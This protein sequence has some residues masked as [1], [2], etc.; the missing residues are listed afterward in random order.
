[1]EPTGA[2]LVH[3]AAREERESMID[4]AWSIG[5]RGRR[6]DLPGLGP[7]AKLTHRALRLLPLL[8]GLRWYAA[9]LAPRHLRL[10]RVATSIPGLP[11]GLSGLR[12]GF[13]T[14]IHHDRGRPLA[15]L[16]RAVALLRD[17]APD[18]ILLGGDYVVGRSRGFAPCARLLGELR[19]PLGVFGILGNHDH[20]GDPAELVRELEAAGITMLRNDARQ[21]AVPG[22]EPLWLV[23][24]DT[25]FRDRADPDAAFA[26]VPGA[27]RR[28]LLLHEPDAAD[29]LARRGLRA[30]LLLAGHTHGGQV[31]LPW[32]GP[33][34]LPPLGRRY[35]RGWHDTL[36]GPLYVS[37]GL[38]AL[39][40]F[41][42][43][44]APPEVTLLTLAPGE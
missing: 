7:V 27:A 43:L 10:E 9:H 41:A 8:P 40:P 22:D 14:D 23:G 15:L 1:M 36:V 42:R 30:D 29:D 11:P 31:A 24:L 38:G 18:L 44:N 12:I 5:W 16:A 4:Q 20:W 28:I 25:A 34:V 33:L 21:L 19:A 37:R 26:D 2:E 13:L 39:P 17:A 35:V 6:Y 3:E 32:L